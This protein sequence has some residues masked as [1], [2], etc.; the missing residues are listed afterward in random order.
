MLKWTGKEAHAW[1]SDMIDHALQHDMPYYWN[2]NWIKPLHKCGDVNL[3][4][5]NY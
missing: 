2:T 5:N 3:N 4:I 1:I